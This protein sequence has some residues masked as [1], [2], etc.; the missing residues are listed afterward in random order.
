[1][2]ISDAFDGDGVSGGEWL[3]TRGTDS[4]IVISSRVRLARNVRS[5]RFAVKADSDERRVIEEEL[6]YALGRVEFDEEMVYLDLEKASPIDAEMLVER[7][8]VSRELARGEGPRA[9]LFAPSETVCVMVC[10]EDHLRLQVLRSGFELDAAWQIADDLDDRIARRVD[11]AFSSRYGYLTCCPTNVGTGLRASVM[12][13]L[14]ALVYSKHIEK[15]FQAGSKMNL[16]VRGLYGEG[17]QALG[18]FYQISNQ[19]ALGLSESDVLERLNRVVPQFID[20]ERRLREALLDGDRARL[21]DRIWRAYG[22]LRAAR[23]ITSE[24]TL[25]LLSAIRL[26]VNLGILPSDLTIESVNELFITS[27]PAHLQKLSAGTMEPRVRDVARAN[28][29]REK[30]GGL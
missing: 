18:D 21:E 24:E 16:A 5:H 2:R 8:L 7:H 19:V 30:L 25:E 27:Q 12:L 1:M 14:P 23:T 6:R 28:L 29:L 15:V 9:A 22:V 4:D 26:G 13:H 17:T 3:S 10:E 11:Y 20:Y